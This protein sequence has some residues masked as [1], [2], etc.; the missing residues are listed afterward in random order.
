MIT[1]MLSQRAKKKPMATRLRVLPILQLKWSD[2]YAGKD[3]YLQNQPTPHF[4]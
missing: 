1:S 3:W 4:F 2:P